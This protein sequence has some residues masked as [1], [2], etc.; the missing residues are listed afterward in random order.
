MA[1]I[2]LDKYLADAGIGTRTEVKAFIKKGY[3]KINDTIAKKPDIKISPVTDT[4]TFQNQP[5]CISSYEYYILNKPQGYVSATKDNTAPTVLSLIKE[6]R[7]DLFPVGRLDK[8]T[9]GLLLITNDGELSHRLLSPKRHVN[10]TYYAITEGLMEEMDILSF[11]NGLKIGDED[12][13]TGSSCQTY[14]I[15]NGSFQKSILYR[16]NSS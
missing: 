10:K 4:I 11:Q 3:V 1:Q 6:G 16:S 15:K 5:I 9:E 7:K 8:D 12:L 13:D 14:H 2:R